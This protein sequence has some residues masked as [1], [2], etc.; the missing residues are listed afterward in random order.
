MRITY[1]EAKR[2]SNIAKHGMDFAELSAE[3]FLSCYVEPAKEGRSLAIGWIDQ[4]IVAAVIFRQ[5]GT[6]AIS[7]VSMRRANRKERSRMNG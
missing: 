3:F 4:A 1:D 2:Q 7:I 6:E 5:L